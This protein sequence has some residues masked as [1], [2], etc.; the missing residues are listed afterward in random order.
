MAWLLLL[1]AVAAANPTP[2]LPSFAWEGT[3][4]YDFGF[5][6]GR[7]FQAEVQHRVQNPDLA[8][9]FLPFYATPQGL[10]I[11][12]AFLQTHNETFTEY[13]LELQGIADGADI[14]FHVIF[15]QNI[16]EE[17]NYYVP[18][19]G[20]PPQQHPYLHCSDYLIYNSDLF[21]DVHNEDY[22]KWSMNT[23]ALVQAVFRDSRNNV[24]SNF[25]GYTYAGDLPTGAFGFNSN[26]IVFSLNYLEPDPSIAVMGG[27]GRG[28]ISRDLLEAKNMTDGVARIT[29]PNQCAGHNYQLMDFTNKQFLNIETGGNQASVKTV[30]IN[31]PPWFHANIYKHLDIKEVINN[32]SVHRQARVDVLPLPK[33]VDDLRNILGDQ[34]DNQYPIFHDDASWANGDVTGDYTMATVVFDIKE[35]SITILHGNPKLPSKVPMI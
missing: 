20:Y 31:D 8:N 10:K 7:H 5:Q 26:G 16:A 24:V 34:V 22:S 6:L 17:Y 1:A 15:I 29:R 23:T 35:A 9:R 19:E 3:S 2:N 33:S 25:T 28:F 30:V 21:V 27:L 13:V 4:H 18:S 12:N 14:S 32:S 11:Y